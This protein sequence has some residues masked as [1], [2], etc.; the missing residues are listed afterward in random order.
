VD[1]K[2][3]Q[4][5]LE[6]LRSYALH[7]D[8]KDNPAYH[9]DHSRYKKIGD[10]G[11]G[12]HHK[13]LEEAQIKGLYTRTHWN[14]KHAAY[15]VKPPTG[16]TTLGHVDSLHLGGPDGVRFEINESGRK[17]ALKTEQKNPH[18]FIHGNVQHS[19][20]LDESD[21]PEGAVPAGY[22][23]KI[24]HFFQLAKGDDGKPTVGARIDKAKDAFLLPPHPD[25]VKTHQAKIDAAVAGGENM[26]Q[27]HAKN[28]AP[29]G[30]V[31]VVPHTDKAT[32]AS[33][34][35]S[36]EVDDGSNPADKTVEKKSKAKK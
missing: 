21:L 36:T 35:A 2:K 20:G 3:I 23:A 24:G 32:K 13:P 1:K 9:L 25:A 6:V 15:S 18:S 8:F 5:V 12:Q 10:M 33:A 34:S 19:G 29:I 17:Q 31:F 28:K 30:R 16:N 4:A 22:S 14:V 11:G 7:P 27:W 26:F